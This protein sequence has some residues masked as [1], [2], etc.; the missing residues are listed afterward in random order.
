MSTPEAGREL[1]R[2]ISL[3]SY[4]A[5]KWIGQDDELRRLSIWLYDENVDGLTFF[6]SDQI[7]DERTISYKFAVGGDGIIGIVYGNQ[8]IWN[9]EDATGIPGWVNITGEEPKYRGLFCAPITYGDLRLGVLSVDR[10]KALKF[11]KEAENVLGAFADMTA[12]ALGN[13]A[14]RTILG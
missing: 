5:L 14:A 8:E 11:D 7:K 13:N 12:V 9:E 2:F 4:E 6:F 1:T 3:R 10:E